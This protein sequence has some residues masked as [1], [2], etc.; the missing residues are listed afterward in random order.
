ML[1]GVHET[2]MIKLGDEIGQQDSVDFY[3]SA[4]QGL[5][6]AV[7]IESDEVLRMPLAALTSASSCSPVWR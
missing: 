7:T 1:V 4:D 6:V 5:E 2:N 3:A